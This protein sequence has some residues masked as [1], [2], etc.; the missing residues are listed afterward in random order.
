M[1]ADALGLRS[2][3]TDS[4]SALMIFAAGALFGTA[5]ALL[6]APRPGD[7]LRADIRKRVSNL[8]RRAASEAKE[9]LGQ[10]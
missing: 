10:A 7:E 3:T 6:F 5:L 9:A 1:I 2:E 4:T 8:Q